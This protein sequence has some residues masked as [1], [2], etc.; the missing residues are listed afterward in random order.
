MDVEEA[1]W[2]FERYPHL[3]AAVQQA[4]AG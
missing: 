2:G 1:R 4:V 3:I